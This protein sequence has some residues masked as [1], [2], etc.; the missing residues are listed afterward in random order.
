[1][2]R[3]FYTFDMVEE[4]LV[5]AMRLW[6]RMPDREKG[7]HAIRAFWPE[8]RRHNHFGD[9]ADTEGSP[10]PLPLT[11]DQVKEM[12]TVGEWIAHH[13]Q[14]RDRQLVVLALMERA[15]GRKQVRWSRIRLRLS[16][17]ISRQGLWMRY[18][19]AIRAIA[20]ALNAAEI[21]GDGV[22]R[23]MVQPM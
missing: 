22:S 18:Q 9:Y 8:M 19:R 2:E 14:E 10:R 11:R 7:W 6:W 23:V 21:R 20:E 4:R 15:K 17:D 13:V 5:E 16:A 3:P 1:M 12:E